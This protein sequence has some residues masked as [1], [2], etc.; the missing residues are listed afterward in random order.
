[1]AKLLQ[2]QEVEVFYV[3]PSLKREIAK[4][5]H[6]RGLRQGKIAD[7][8]QIEKA[9]VSQY[10]SDKRG[11]KVEFSEEFLEKVY[12][13][14]RRIEDK[15]SFIREIQGLLNKARDDGTV[16]VVHKKVSDI[17]EDCTPEK[18]N[19]FGKGGCACSDESS[20]SGGCGG[21]C[22]CSSEMSGGGEHGRYTSAHDR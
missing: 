1:M 16:C 20:E 22:A 4:C 18:A 9:T 17:P 21:G 3:I 14:A 8:L 5:M 19:C 7:L 2:P 13:S 12:E 11:T 10:L 6:A 15:T